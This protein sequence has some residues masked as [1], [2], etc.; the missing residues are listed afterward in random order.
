[1][2]NHFGFGFHLR[3][4]VRF[5]IEQLPECTSQRRRNTIDIAG[6][7]RTDFLFRFAI[8]NM[9]EAIGPGLVSVSLKP[10]DTCSN[11]EVAR[12]I[13]LICESAI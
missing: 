7:V 4:L 3:Q 11:Q 5:V 12:R 13:V 9:L 1:V 2:F 8:D 10:G 6:L